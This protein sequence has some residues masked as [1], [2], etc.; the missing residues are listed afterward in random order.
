MFQDFFAFYGSHIPELEF[1][2]VGKLDLV[3]ESLLSSELAS[4]PESTD[5][6]FF[7]LPP[8]E[9]ASSLFSFSFFFLTSSKS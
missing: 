2:F 9:D 7:I 1:S 3:V 8:L 6:F 4:F 5:E